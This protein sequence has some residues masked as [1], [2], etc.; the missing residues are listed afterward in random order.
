MIKRHEYF[1]PSLPPTSD[2]IAHDR[3]SAL[4][5]MLLAKPFE[6][7]FSRVALLFRLRFIRLE[8]FVD[9]RDKRPERL[10][11]AIYFPAIA[12]RLDMFKRLSNG[13]PVE[14]ILLGRLANTELAGQ[15]SQANFCPSVH[16]VKHSFPHDSKHY[17]N[18]AANAANS[19]IAYQSQDGGL[20]ALHF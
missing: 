11:R 10:F 12:G 7:P 14:P 16:V 3:D 13:P 18:Y 1:S 15:N 19:S 9:D 5:A 4:I 2:L 20:R 17:S 8:N 6:N